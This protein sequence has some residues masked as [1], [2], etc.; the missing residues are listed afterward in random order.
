MPTV[1]TL[2]A[3]KYSLSTVSSKQFFRSLLPRRLLSGFLGL[4]LAPSSPHDNF[5]LWSYNILTDCYVDKTG[6]I[7]PVLATST[8]RFTNWSPIYI[9]TFIEV[10][11][12]LFYNR[13]KFFAVRTVCQSFLSQS[14]KSRQLMPICGSTLPCCRSYFWQLSS[15]SSTF[16]IEVRRKL[17][18]TTQ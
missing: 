1:K 17:L 11:T 6:E 13:W 7:G 14:G 16:C 9:L 18:S 15:N 10:I 2:T 4:L 3:K 5:S 12:G 8:I